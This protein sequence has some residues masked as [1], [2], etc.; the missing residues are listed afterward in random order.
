MPKFSQKSFSNLATCHM[1]LQV[2]FY[3]VIKHFDCTILEGHRGEAAQNAAYAAGN[4]KLM[5]PHGKHNATPSNAVD[6]AP[7]PLPL[8]KNTNDFFYFGGIVM[9][10]AAMLLAEGKMTHKIRY[11][12]D[13][14]QNGR[15]S[16]STF[17]D[18]VHFEL[19][20]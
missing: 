7:W 18:A 4:S 9:G 12:G 11:G 13:F 10:I 6:V 15:V 8:W 19:V 5:Y 17:V 14:N 16:D 2:L 1:D 20:I 3:E